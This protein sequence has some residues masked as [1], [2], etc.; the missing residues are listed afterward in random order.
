MRKKTR[1][2]LIEL[3]RQTRPA[4]ILRAAGLCDGHTIFDP[5]A[6]L[7]AGLAIE[8]V[9][10]LTVVHRSDTRDPKATI[11]KEGRA[12]ADMRGVYGLHVLEFLAGAFGVEYRGCMGRG[13]QASAIRDALRQHFN[14]SAPSSSD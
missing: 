11:F 14:S 12:V 5:K 6:F 9:E 8:I 10:H 2:H 1:D 3:V 13:F 7:E 4:I